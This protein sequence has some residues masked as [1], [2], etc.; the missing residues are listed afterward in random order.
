MNPWVFAI[1]IG[2]SAILSLGSVAASIRIAHKVGA[3]DRP[4][5][6]RKIQD[7]PIPQLGGVAVAFALLVAVITALE[8]LNRH[9]D[10]P[11]ALS[12]LGPALGVAILGYL[13]DI[14]EINPWVRLGSQAA[15]ALVAWFAGTQVDVFGFAAF[16]AA[17]MVIWTVAIVNGFNLLDN[18]DGLAGTT[19][20]VTSI[21]AG[22]IA[23]ISGQIIISLVAFSIT[24]ISIG[25]LWHNWYPARVYLG[26]SGAYFLGFLLAVLTIRLRPMES[27]QAIGILI[28]ILLML[29][30]IVDTTYVVISRLRKGIHPFTAGRDHLSH[31]LQARGATVSKSVLIPTGVLVISSSLAVLLAFFTS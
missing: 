11:L 3:V 7:R 15:L 12:V 6:E 21:G 14:R 10:I 1:V 13:D 8:L 23:V 25:F 2:G 26:D 28:A 17:I 9:T 18:T 27:P 19:A 29:L 30:P 5:S 24:G 16:D 22:I 31:V 20:L 4:D